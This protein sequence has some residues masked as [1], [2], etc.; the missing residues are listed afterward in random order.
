M[1]LPRKRIF[2][3]DASTQ[4]DPDTSAA[5]A[6]KRDAVAHF[7]AAIPPDDVAALEADDL[8]AILKA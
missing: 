5:H 3:A 1:A 7:R 2:S 6:P 4:T 8:R